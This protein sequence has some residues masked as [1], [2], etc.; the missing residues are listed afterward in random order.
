MPTN[1][2][3]TSV[4]DMLPNEKGEYLVVYHPCHWDRVHTDQIFVGLDTFRGKTTWAKKKYQK[5]THWT[6]LPEPPKEGSIRRQT[7]APVRK[8][9]G[10]SGGT[11]MKEHCIMCDPNESEHFNEK[12]TDGRTLWGWV[13]EFNLTLFTEIK[14]GG[15]CDSCVEIPISFCPFCGRCLQQ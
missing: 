8:S 15:K 13:G 2:N 3:W 10:N 4:D 5:V 1:M 14:D 11:P 6:P 7:G 12:M 9:C